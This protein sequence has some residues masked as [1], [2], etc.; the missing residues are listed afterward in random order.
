MGRDPRQPI[1][2]A[3]LIAVVALF[4]VIAFLVSFQ[5]T[6]SQ[7][8]IPASCV[9]E[10]APIIKEAIGGHRP[11]YS[12]LLFSVDEHAQ[13]HRSLGHYRTEAE[14]EKRTQHYSIGKPLVCWVLKDGPVDVKTVRLEILGEA[15]PEFTKEHELTLGV[16]AALL[17][18]TLLSCV[19][20]E[21]CAPC[22]VAHRVV[23][24]VSDEDN[25]E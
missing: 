21:M 7:G 18:L 24:D 2:V 5:I 22:G 13:I 17:A 16:A 25:S 19:M 1:R 4:G 15:P 11:Y 14:A 8:F 12:Y 20:F 9:V 3:H 6:A 23:A 10:G